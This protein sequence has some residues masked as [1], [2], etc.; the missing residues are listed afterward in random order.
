[1]AAIQEL[2]R[3]NDSVLNSVLDEIKAASTIIPNF[4]LSI[5]PLTNAVYCSTGGTGGTGGTT[6]VIPVGIDPVN[7]QTYTEKMVLSYRIFALWQDVLVSNGFVS[8]NPIAY[9]S[10]FLQRSNSPQLYAQWT[11]IRL[12]FNENTQQ[13]GDLLFEYGLPITTQTPEEYTSAAEKLIADPRYQAI[14]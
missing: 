9:V 2:A 3:L 6:C 13:F 1:L 12:D 14:L 4:V 5:T 8:F 7:P 11:A 10:N